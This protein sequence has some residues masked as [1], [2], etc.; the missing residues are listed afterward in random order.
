MPVA[1][2][3][4]LNQNTITGS[5]STMTLSGLTVPA[6]ALVAVVVRVG[7]G[8]LVTS[9]SDSANSTWAAGTKDIAS[10]NGSGSNVFIYS[11]VL[12]KPLSSGSITV[13]YGASSNVSVVI[14][15]MNGTLGLSTHLDQTSAA[16]STSNVTSLSIP[17]TASNLSTAGEIVL[18][19]LAASG[20]VQS[21]ATASGYTI[22]S[23]LTA[24]YLAIAYKTPGSTLTAPSASWS[25]VGSY[26]VGGAIAT[27]LPHPAHNMMATFER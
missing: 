9:V 27:Y 14:L 22:V 10:A 23:T 6:G 19:A 8:Q 2:P 21:N 26:N 13:N 17:A 20:P 11:S 25:W 16:G 15:R 24:T 3:T 7:G 1:A 4:V 5:S 18:T 12:V